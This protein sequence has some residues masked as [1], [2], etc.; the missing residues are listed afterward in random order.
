ML[1]LLVVFWNRLCS[2]ENALQKKK[3]KENNNN[4]NKKKDRL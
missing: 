3:R 4:N 1:I 2:H